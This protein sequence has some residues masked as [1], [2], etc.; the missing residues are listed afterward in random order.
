VLA[1]A[2]GKGGCGKTTTALGLARALDAP[3]LVVDAD[4]D[5]PDLHAL[6]D[7]PRTPT[8]L[9]VASDPLASAQ[10]D[11]GGDGVALLPAPL[12]DCT[13]DA[14]VH[15]ALARCA[16]ADCP[17][18]VD[19]P[20]GAGPDAAVPLRTAD[21]TVLVST[22]CAPALQDGA[23]TAAMART[24]DAAPVGSVLTRTHVAP[25]GLADLLGCPTVGTVPDVDPP[26]LSHPEV[27][28]A[29]TRISDRL[30]VR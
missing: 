23:K 9:D 21:A 29:Y 20:S 28:R 16:D 11:P 12:P 8:L 4:R 22:V 7:V 13:D 17:V 30:A 14:A 10:P 27:S 18:V 6:A 1:I 15:A 19:C 24:L 3:T 26:V 5:M 25:D 2:G